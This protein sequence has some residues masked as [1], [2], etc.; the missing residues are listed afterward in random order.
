[1]HESVAHMRVHRSK[2]SKKM[3]E[4]RSLCS[5][6]LLFRFLHREY[7]HL[8]DGKIQFPY[9]YGIEL[10]FGGHATRQLSRK[11]C[12]LIF[13]APNGH[14][15]HAVFS[16]IGILSAREHKQQ[17]GLAYGVLAFGFGH[18]PQQGIS[19]YISMYYTDF[20]RCFSGNLFGDLA[21]KTQTNKIRVTDHHCR[22]IPATGRLY[23]CLLV[24]V[25]PM[26]VGVSDRALWCVR[27]RQPFVT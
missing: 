1:M 19:N 3:G 12:G 17:I 8:S 24:A 22:I 15:K 20:V 10:P 7:I 13:Q 27:L 5:D 16:A 25:I 26:P 6:I 21:V 14:H 11:R 18:F 9:A 23:V 2:S 4:E